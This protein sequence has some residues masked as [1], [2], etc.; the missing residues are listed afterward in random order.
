MNIFVEFYWKHIKRYKPY[1]N[2]PRLVGVRPLENGRLAL[3]FRNKKNRVWIKELMIWDDEE[4]RIYDLWK[5]FASRKDEPVVS[6]WY[7]ED[8]F[9]RFYFYGDTLSWGSGL[10]LGADYLYRNSE[11]VKGDFLCLR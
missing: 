2:S 1:S 3:A 4:L 11:V 8:F 6:K 7:K 9:Y 10:D 5:D